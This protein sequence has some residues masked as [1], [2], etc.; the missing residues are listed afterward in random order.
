MRRWIVLIICLTFM[1][2]YAL[3]G[4]GIFADVKTR[5]KRD[6]HKYSLLSPR[7][8]AIV[9]L[10]A[11]SAIGANSYL[12]DEIENAL[13]ARHLAPEDVV[14]ILN[15]LTSYYGF[16]RAEKAFSALDGLVDPALA[17]QL[18]AD[19]MSFRHKTGKDAYTKLDPNGYAAITN[20]FGPLAKNLPDTT[21]PLFGDA[22]SPEGL[23][24]PDRQLATIAA[25][26][27]MDTAEPQ[28]RFHI[29]T[30]L[31]IGLSRQDIM[32]MI[33][34]IQYYAGMPAAYNG[35][36]AAKAVFDEVDKTPPGK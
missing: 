23:S 28:L 31:R 25:L 11:L 14:L 16:P 30:S 13:V 35:A 10:A 3:A 12:R 4:D 17:F 32:D 1:P 29:R 15:Q 20:M 21:F 8:Q 27:A 18:P 2:A 22:Y 19:E 24:L 9:Q 36:L 33:V 26:A 7:Q 6:V 5:A 34:L